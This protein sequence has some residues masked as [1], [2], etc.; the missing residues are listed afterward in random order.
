[1]ALNLELAEGGLRL[2]FVGRATFETLED[3]NDAE[4]TGPEPFRDL[5]RPGGR[6][7]VGDEGADHEADDEADGYGNHDGAGGTGVVAIGEALNDRGVERGHRRV[8][9]CG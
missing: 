7:G 2:E 1:M 5:L 8:R 9:R 4:D 6:E 3:P